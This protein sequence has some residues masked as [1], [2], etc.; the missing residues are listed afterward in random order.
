[1][2]SHIK[3]ISLKTVGHI[4]FLKSYSLLPNVEKIRANRGI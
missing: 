1:M 2:F 3:R 4:E